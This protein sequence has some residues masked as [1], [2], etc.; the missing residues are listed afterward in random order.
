MELPP[1]AKFQVDRAP[2]ADVTGEVS[3]EAVL[4]N[5]IPLRVT[6]E[7]FVRY[8]LPDPF[9]FRSAKLPAPMEDP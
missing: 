5:S 7:P 6:P 2:L 3:R 1:L 4:R 8:W 9:E